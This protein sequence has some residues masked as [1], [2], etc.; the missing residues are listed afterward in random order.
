VFSAEQWH[1]PELDGVEPLEL[2]LT[3]WAPDEATDAFA[4]RYAELSARRG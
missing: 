2:D 4:R 3:A 1:W